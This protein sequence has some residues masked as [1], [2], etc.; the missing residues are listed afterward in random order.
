MHPIE[1]L[2]DA[3][4]REVA[5]P[6]I[7]EA[8]R[9]LT[10][11]SSIDDQGRPWIEVAAHLTG[12]TTN[13]LRLGQRTFTMITDFIVK[14]KLPVHALDWHISSLEVITRISKIDSRRAKDILTSK[15]QYSLR[16]LRDLYDKTRDE[17]GS[18]VSAMSAGHKAAKEFTK[19]LLSTLSDIE[20]LREFLSLDQGVWLGSLKVWP[21]RHP[22]VHPDFYIDFTINGELH[23]AAFEGLRFY[24]DVTSQVATKAALKAAV[25]AT[26]FS[27]YYWCIPSWISTVDLERLREELGLLNVGIV[28]ISEAKIESILHPL[29]SSVHDRQAILLKDKAILQRLKVH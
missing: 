24:G 16:Q 12:Y 11:A 15:N 14:N 25:E 10:K 6:L 8:L 29:G 7:V 19:K 3:R 17:A 4:S 26:F 9:E 28:T 1:V 27:Q 20:C 5:W 18:K 22:Y 2:T 21:G 23:L 13:H